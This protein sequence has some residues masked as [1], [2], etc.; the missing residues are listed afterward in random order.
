M[1]L[2]PNPRPGMARPDSMPPLGEGYPFGAHLQ[3]IRDTLKS[4]VSRLN[5]HVHAIAREPSPPPAPFW[6]SLP[7][8]SLPR[9]FS[10]PSTSGTPPDLEHVLPPILSQSRGI[11]MAEAVRDIESDVMI[12]HVSGVVRDLGLDLM[13]GYVADVVK[14]V[15]LDVMGECVADVVRVAVLE[16]MGK[17]IS[18]VMAEGV[19]SM[20]EVRLGNMDVHRTHLNVTATVDV[21]EPPRK[22]RPLAP[23]FPHLHANQAIVEQQELSKQNHQHKPHNTK[24]VPAN[25]KFRRLANISTLT[26]T[27]AETSLLNKGL[28][29]IPAPPDEHKLHI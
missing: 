8:A 16:V 26:I 29:F 7:R 20:S 17:C 28:S 2:L 10:L 21:P 14:D 4:L 19:Q 13:G 22:C 6:L 5:A 27:R 18:D 25:G 9:K 15:G 1:P 3:D 24:V 23:N 11:C 12:E